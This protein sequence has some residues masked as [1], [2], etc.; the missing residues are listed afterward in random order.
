MFPLNFSHQETTQQL[1]AGACFSRPKSEAFQDTSSSDI[2]EIVAAIDSGRAWQEIV[3]EKY[4][5]T[6]PWLDQIIRSPLRSSFFSELVPPSPGLALDIG[7]GWGQMTRPLAR[8]GWSV[9]ALEPSEARM[10]FVQSSVR[11]DKLDDRVAFLT[12]DFL[13]THFETKFDL[14]LCIG[15][16]E[17]VGAFQA[18]QDPLE[19]QR[20]FLRKVKQ[21]LT[22]DGSLIIGI[23]NRLGLKYLLGTPDDHIGAPS[24]AFLPAELASRRWQEETGHTLRSFTYTD[25]ELRALLTEAGFT[26]IA[27]YA[28]LPDYKL[29]EK[30]ITLSEGGRHFNDFVASGEFV[31]EHNGYD[32][33]KLTTIEQENLS[34]TY[35]SMAMQGIAHHFAPSF[36]IK[37]C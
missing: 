1:N 20:R 6:N 29:A 14:C 30:I 11:Q 3:R 12:T 13:E 32:G 25:A 27:F 2:D 21:E 7:C 5:K 37:A 15:V 34:A 9:A 19:R 33:T 23:E 16:L 31:P 28:A 4:G 17:W 26:N 10:S 24:V 22:P 36:F 8:D 18:D 35:A